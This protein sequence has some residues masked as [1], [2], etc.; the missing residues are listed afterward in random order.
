MKLCNKCTKPYEDSFSFCPHCGTPGA[1]QPSTEAQASESPSPEAGNYQEQTRPASPQPIAARH[2]G[3]FVGLAL[4]ALVI[5]IAVQISGVTEI[6]RA[7][8]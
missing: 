5:I 4:S 2:S 3:L 6:G 8:V 1:H 7:H